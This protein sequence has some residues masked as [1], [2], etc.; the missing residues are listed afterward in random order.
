M[1][2][3]LWSIDASRHSTIILP[4]WSLMVLWRLLDPISSAQGGGRNIGWTLNL[5]QIHSLNMFIVY[6]FR[7]HIMWWTGSTHLT[8]RNQHVH[9]SWCLLLVVWYKRPFSLCWLKPHF[10]RCVVNF[11][12]NAYLH[13]CPDKAYLGGSETQAIIALLHT[14]TLCVVY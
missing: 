4:A 10:M 7:H 2:Q 14:Y 3:L 12:L 5:K 9:E 1:N 13:S 11:L 6:L 8:T